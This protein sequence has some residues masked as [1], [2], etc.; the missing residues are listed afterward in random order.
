[1]AGDAERNR[2]ERKTPPFE[3]RRADPW[4]RQDAPEL[5][6]REPHDVPVKGAKAS[7]EPISALEYLVDLTGSR[8]SRVDLC[9]H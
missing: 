7:E 4:R 1:V 6:T 5:A 9:R 8:P 2:V 3:C